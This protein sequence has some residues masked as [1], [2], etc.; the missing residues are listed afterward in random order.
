MPTK[1]VAFAVPLANQA[2][3]FQ[4]IFVVFAKLLALYVHQDVKFFI[5]IC[6]DVLSTDGACAVDC[7]VGYDN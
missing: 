4:G 6:L 3:T 2:T 7:P 5:F 1:I